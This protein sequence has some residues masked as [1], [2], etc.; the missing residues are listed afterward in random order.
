MDIS[1]CGCLCNCSK[2]F[3]WLPT[4]L[5]VSPH[6]AHSL[7]QS[8]SQTQAKG[9]SIKIFKQAAGCRPPPASLDP[10]GLPVFPSGKAVLVVAAADRAVSQQHRPGFQIQWPAVALRLQSRAA[11]ARRMGLIC[12]ARRVDPLGTARLFLNTAK[13]LFLATVTQMLA[14]LESA[15][16]MP[17]RVMVDHD[18]LLQG[19]HPCDSPAGICVAR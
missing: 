15:D 17:A 9:C 14:R 13:L 7:K 10:E 5:T 16:A 12:A 18:R 3:H 8:Q 1:A 11:A 4:L 6:K 19:G 2:R